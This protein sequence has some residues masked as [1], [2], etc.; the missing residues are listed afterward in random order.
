MF[1]RTLPFSNMKSEMT[2]GNDGNTRLTPA[3]TSLI[4]SYLTVCTNSSP[5]PFSP[6]LPPAS[7]QQRGH[8]RANKHNCNC[9][10]NGTALCG[11]FGSLFFGEHKRSFS[12]GTDKSFANTKSS[13]FFLTPETNKHS[14]GR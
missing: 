11:S 12:D 8:K 1:L 6:S 3:L 10:C 7:V 13:S 14:E 4:Q 9:S 2:I 5:P